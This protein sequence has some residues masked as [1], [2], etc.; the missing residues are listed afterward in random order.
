MRPTQPQLRIE[1]TLPPNEERIC[2]CSDVT[3]QWGH[4]MTATSSLPP[5]GQDGG[6]GGGGGGGAE[7][8]CKLSNTTLL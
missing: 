7:T 1:A 2:L 8:C 4:K 6:G 5:R 3:S